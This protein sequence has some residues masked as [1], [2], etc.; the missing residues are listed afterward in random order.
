MGRQK[1]GIADGEDADGSFNKARYKATKVAGGQ[2]SHLRS[3]DHLGTSCK[4]KEKKS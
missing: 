2:G 4:V 1:L 3:L